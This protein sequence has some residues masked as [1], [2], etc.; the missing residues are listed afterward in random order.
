MNPSNQWKSRRLSYLGTVILL[1]LLSPQGV[2]AKSWISRD[3]LPEAVKASL[4]GELPGKHVRK[5]ERDVDENGETVYEID[6]R[7]NDRGRETELTVAED[8]KI[9]TKEVDGKF[10]ILDGQL[11]MTDEEFF[12]QTIRTPSVGDPSVGREG[13][14]KSLSALSR[15]GGNT[16][17][18]DLHGFNAEGSSLSA[19]SVEHV[20][21][22]VDDLLDFN[23]GGLCRVLGPDAPKS[24]EGRRNAVR[25]AAKAFAED[26]QV[27]FWIDGE[28]ASSLASEFSRVSPHLVVAAP[29]AEFETVESPPPNGAPLCLITGEE[30]FSLEEDT[31]FLL[32]DVE[33]SYARIDAF[34]A[35][36]VEG[37]TFPTTDFGL[38]PEEKAEGFVSLFD[39]ETLNGWSSVDDETDSFVAEDG[40][41]KWVRKG[42]GALQTQ[43][44]YGDFILR[45]EYKI[46]DGGN[47]GL[48][49]RAPRE[50]RASK[51]GFEVQILGDYGRRPHKNGTGSIYDVVA[52]TENASKPSGE[53]NTLEVV[54]DGPRVKV[55]L[56]G[57]KVQ[58][59]NFDDHD[60]LRYRLRNGFIRLTDH[61]N[62]VW[63]RRIRIR[64][65]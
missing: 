53:W 19:E 26:P 8:G 62:P 39:G 17:A 63:Y 52:P 6:L 48:H 38:S 12:V 35:L 41:I 64:E 58:D 57:K 33:K 47:S 13:F 1:V 4:E 37:K 10:F 29:D 54:A 14:L 15:V 16:V 56:N 55:T 32:P 28:E 5:I 22:I 40:T 7:T 11:N 59:V 36:P 44:R 30:D 18:F 9:V 60:A 21:S 34:R 27:I 20:R 46:S 51:I 3:K 31:H 49:L 2:S 25:T 45:C 43:K 42:A 23:A 61:G 50:N 65:L 24:P